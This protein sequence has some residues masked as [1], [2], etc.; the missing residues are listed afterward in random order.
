MRSLVITSGKGGVGKTTVTVYL[1]RALASRGYRVAAIDADTGLNNLDVVTGIEGRVTYDLSDVI[2]GRCRPRQALVPD[3]VARGF[4]VMPSVGGYMDSSVSSQNIAA[5]LNALAV[6]F[7]FALVDCP[8]G[9]ELGF[10]RAVAAC[11]EALVVTTP[12]LSAIRDA[13]K[14]IKILQTYGTAYKTV[15]NRM[16]KDLCARGKIPSDKTVGAI[17]SCEIAGVIPDIDVPSVKDRK[18]VK[19]FDALACGIAMSGAGGRRYAK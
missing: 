9:I 15:I 7:D 17:L 19:A 12:H 13:D 16:R 11:D 4:Y 1:G 6:T 8:A 14:V 5:V 10:H 18:F 2:C 3:E